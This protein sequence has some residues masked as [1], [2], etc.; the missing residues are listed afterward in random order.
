MKNVNIASKIDDCK[1]I[2]CNLSNVVKNAF[3]SFSATKISRSPKWNT[4]LSL[5]Y[6]SIDVLNTFWVVKPG[7][8]RFNTSHTLVAAGDCLA[9]HPIRSAQCHAIVVC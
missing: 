2:L 9:P 3:D 4:Q 1:A 7:Q 5:S 6:N 8:Y